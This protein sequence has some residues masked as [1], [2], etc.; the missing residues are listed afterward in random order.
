MPS[1]NSK[2]WRYLDFAKFMSL[3]D[4]KNLFFVRADNLPDKF[5]GF[6]SKTNTELDQ[7]LLDLKKETYLSCWHQNEIE[8][9]TMWEVYPKSDYGIAIKSN[10]KRLKESLNEGLNRDIY[11]D[12]VEYTDIILD[13]I[14]KISQEPF[15]RK[16]K[17]FKED[18][19]IRAIIQKINPK[20]TEIDPSIK[21]VENGLYVNVSLDVLIEEIITSPNAP[22]YF[23]N[24]V[25]SIV[26]KYRL[27]KRVIKSSL[28]DIPAEVPI[29]KSHSN[30]VEVKQHTEADYSGNIKLVNG[31]FSVAD[32]TK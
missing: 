6:W 13:T 20:D 10:F 4:S 18:N 11:I 3:L 24:L 8:S 19:E 22:E 31:T 2:L 15:V 30:G 17:Y 26:N 9:A 12:K 16:R 25:Q 23:N 14:P 28:G 7:Y 5:E 27:N 21:V 1:D 29:N 32:Q